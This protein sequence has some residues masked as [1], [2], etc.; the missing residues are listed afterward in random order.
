MSIEVTYSDGKTKT[1]DLESL[2]G[3]LSKKV[4]VR[5]PPHSFDAVTFANYEGRWC[6]LFGGRGVDL[7]DG[8]TIA[9]TGGTSMK[10]HEKKTSP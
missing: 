7:T 2:R 1:Y 8:A 5:V 9:T 6:Y 4:M 10:F 3:R